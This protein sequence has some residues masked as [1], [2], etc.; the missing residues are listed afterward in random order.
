MSTELELVERLIT[1]YEG[2][3]NDLKS[4]GD[5]YES[6]HR[7]TAVGLAT[8]P[9]MQ[10]LLSDI[11]WARVYLDSLEERLDLEGFRM[12][13]EDASDERLWQ[14]WQANNLD[15]MSGLGH[16]EAFVHGR[17]FVVVSAPK[18]GDPLADPTCPVIDVLSPRQMHADIDRRTGKV[19]RAIRFVK[20]WGDPSDTRPD[21]VTLYLPNVTVAYERSPQGWTELD[22]VPHKL[23]VVPVVPLLNKSR[24]DQVLG[25]SEIKQELRS[26]TDAAARTMMNLQAT[27]ELMAIPQRYIFGVDKDELMSQSGGSTYQAYIAKILAFTDADGKAGQFIAAELRNFTEVM[28]ELSKQAASY[29]G[30]PPQYLSFASENPASAEAIRSSETRLIKKA[31]RKAKVFGAA[32]EQ[33]MRLCLLVMDGSVSS[34]AHR[35]ETIW[36]DPATP[37]FAAMSDAVVKLV[38]AATPDGRPLVP[39][40]MGRV[41]LGFSPEERRQME[42]WDKEAPR[43]QL[44]SLLTTPP[45]PAFSDNLEQE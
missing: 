33:V 29:T 27:M 36:R 6:R 2:S 35:M 7:P 8:P 1:S 21:F 12:A 34:D 17:A 11:G 3:K 19:L 24:L 15:Q 14:W 5:Y 22:R 9:A 13:G 32:W 43:Q 45:K 25:Q 38:T 16:L 18:K 39:V 41:K 31:E 26:V 20:G 4:G 30:L 28:T 37:T 44:A 10:M 23:G 42:A 40:E